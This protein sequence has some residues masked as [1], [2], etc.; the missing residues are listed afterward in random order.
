[1]AFDLGWP[2]FTLY[3]C[4]TRL[5][6]HLNASIALWQMH[7]CSENLGF[8][9][10]TFVE[11]YPFG[12][13]KSLKEDNVKF[14]M[15]F[16]KCTMVYNTNFLRNQSTCIVRSLNF[17]FFLFFKSILGFFIS[18]I[19]M[20]LQFVDFPNYSKFGFLGNWCVVFWGGRRSEV[21]KFRVLWW[22]GIAWDAIYFGNGISSMPYS[23]SLKVGPLYVVFDLNKVLVTTRFDRGG[24]WKV[25]SCIFVFNLKFKKFLERCVA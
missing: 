13:I 25:P 14:R 6:L 17:P 15:L 16:E 3:W 4:D 19:Y 11:D 18:L 21:A 1:M 9:V 24:Y 8:S 23:P 22:L 7:R 12:S 2:K 5:C 10:P 20:V